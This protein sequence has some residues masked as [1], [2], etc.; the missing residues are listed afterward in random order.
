MYS[1]HIIANCPQSMPV[2][3]FWKL[4]KNWRWYGQ[5]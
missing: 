3:E 1:N 5:K 2:K 4:D